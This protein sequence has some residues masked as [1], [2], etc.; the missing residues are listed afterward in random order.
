MDCFIASRDCVQSHDAS[1][2]DGF[3]AVR[4]PASRYQSVIVQDAITL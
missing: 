4:A 2:N 1:R 3:G